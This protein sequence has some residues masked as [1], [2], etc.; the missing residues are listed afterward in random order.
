MWEDGIT[1]TSS[2]LE[3]LKFS[4]FPFTLIQF[5]IECSPKRK[6]IYLFLIWHRLYWIRVENLMDFS[7][8][9]HF[10]FSIFFFFFFYIKTDGMDLFQTYTQISFINGIHSVKSWTRFVSKN[11]K[12]MVHT[13]RNKNIFLTQNTVISFLFSYFRITCAERLNSTN[14]KLYGEGVR[15]WWFGFKLKRTLNL[16]MF[17]YACREQMEEWTPFDCDE[18]IWSIHYSL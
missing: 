1:I 15:W 18:L 11:R 7:K 10:F 5:V 9:W 12:K 13:W 3:T 16:E 14:Y 17:I 8:G 2:L 6:P 4:T